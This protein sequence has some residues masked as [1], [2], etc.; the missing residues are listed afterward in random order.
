MKLTPLDLSVETMLI[1]GVIS[2]VVSVPSVM[3]ICFKSQ[4]KREER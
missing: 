1:V 4:N 3:K 2:S